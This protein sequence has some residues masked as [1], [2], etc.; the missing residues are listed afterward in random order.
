MFIGCRGTVAVVAPTARLSVSR[1]ASDAVQVTPSAASAGARNGLSFGCCGSVARPLCS[2]VTSTDGSNP[3][4]ALVCAQV[5][6]SPIADVRY[7]CEAYQTPS[8]PAACATSGSNRGCS[9]AEVAQCQVPVTAAGAIW[10][11]PRNGCVY[12]WLIHGK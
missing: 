4:R 9:V 12:V 3:G 10:M 2:P 11:Q 1:E 6:L 7:A 8:G 5:M